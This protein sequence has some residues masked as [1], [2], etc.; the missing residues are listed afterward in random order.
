VLSHFR[1]RLLL[2]AITVLTALTGQADV[3]RLAAS[4]PGIPVVTSVYTTG[5]GGTVVGQTTATPDYVEGEVLVKYKAQTQSGAQASVAARYGMTEQRHVAAL[6]LSQ[7]KLAAGQSVQAAM[8]TL[9]LDPAVEYVQPNYIYHTLATPTDPSYG[10]QWGFKNTGQTVVGGYSPNTGTPGSDMNLEPAW[11]YITD[12]SPVVVAIVDTGMNYLHQDLAANMW[13]GGVAYPHHGYD[14]V[15]NDNDPFASDAEGHATHV[16]A[17][18]GAAA[19]NNVAGAGVCWTARIMSVRVLGPGGSGTTAS[20]ASGVNFAATNGARVINMSLGGSAFDQVFSDAITAAGNAGVLV[21][22]AAGNSAANND[23]TSTYPC[24]FTQANLICVAALD[25]NYNLASFSNYGATTV[26]VGA[27]GTNVLSAWPGQHLTDDFSTWTR[28]GGWAQVSCA[29]LAG[30]APTP[31]LVNPANW[32]SNGTYANNA[33]DVAYRTFNFSTAAAYHIAFY[34]MLN[35]EVNADFL[36]FA[37]NPNGGDPFGAGGIL[38]TEN[39]SANSLSFLNFSDGVHVCTTANCSLGVRLRSNATNVYRGAGLFYATLDT[40][41][42]NSTDT[43]I[44]NGTSMATP[45]V[46]GLAAMLM[47]YNPDFNVADTAAAI[48]NGGRSVPA[49]AG[50][51]VTGRAAD[52]FGSLSYLQP[53]T[54]TAAV[55]Q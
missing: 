48:K 44:I 33:N 25:Q 5:A 45:H 1:L 34:A 41:I 9:A 29:P 13:D 21:V 43:L 42:N 4:T 53:P 24:N 31:M 55:V 16:A 12:C 22:V 3:S 15:N 23:T 28:A 18:I 38:V 7:L 2:T 6:R 40:T 11:D 47:A 20:I 10:L 8:A 26:D 35:L 32:C 37:I 19:N 14:F 46:T 39:S 30:L 49:L 27:P 50:K 52:A 51:T 54:G 36:G 17:T